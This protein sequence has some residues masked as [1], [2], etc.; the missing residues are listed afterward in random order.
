MIDVI[1]SELLDAKE[2]AKL[3]PFVRNGK[4]AS[5]GTIYRILQRGA[6][7][8][9]GKLIKLECVKTPSGIK[10]SR[11]A[12]AEFVQRLT[13]P[14]VAPGTPR[15][16]TPRQRAKRVEKAEAELSAAGIK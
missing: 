15:A 12:V 7:A 2:I 10:T 8:I 14:A 4:A 1:N 13:D 11:E 3:P 16:A 9:N 6:R 5:R